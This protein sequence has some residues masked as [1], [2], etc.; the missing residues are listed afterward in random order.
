MQYV[1]DNFDCLCQK[2]HE[3]GQKEPKV[4]QSDSPLLIGVVNGDDLVKELMNLSILINNKD[5]YNF[6][7]LIFGVYF[8][9][10]SALIV[11]GRTLCTL[12]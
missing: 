3:A 5:R 11:W 1:L 12:Y 9:C 10:C 7:I 2:Q 8:K 4:A 6:S